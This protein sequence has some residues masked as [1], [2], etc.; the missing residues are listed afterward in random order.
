MTGIKFC[1][2]AAMEL[3]FAAIYSTSSVYYL[4]ASHLQKQVSRSRPISGHTTNIISDLLS[5]VLFIIIRSLV[6][7]RQCA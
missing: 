2:Y 5:L 6:I 7:W 4:L 3:L 1:L